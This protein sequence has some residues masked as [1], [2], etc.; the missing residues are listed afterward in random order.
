VLRGAA[1]RLLEPAKAA[2]AVRA[3]VQSADGIRLVHGIG[4][5]S[6]SAPEDADRLLP[7]V[8]DGLRPPAAVGARG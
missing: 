1:G 8:L 3:E 4:M 2:G 5:A 7:F 6:E